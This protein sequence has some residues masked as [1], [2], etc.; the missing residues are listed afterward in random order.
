MLFQKT[1]QHH[2]MSLRLMRCG[3]TLVKK[4]YTLGLDCLCPRYQRNPYLCAS[5]GG[6]TLKQLLNTIRSVECRLYFAP[7]SWK[8]YKKYLP[9]DK[10]IASKTE[11]HCIASQNCRVRHYLARFTRKTLCYSK[12]KAMVHLSLALLFFSDLCRI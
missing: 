1:Y 7:D 6:K 4:T 5:R 9:P 3:I 11:T 12:S 2:V 8:M 10:H